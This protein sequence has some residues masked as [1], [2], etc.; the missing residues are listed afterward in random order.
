M[1]WRS[2]DPLVGVL[3]VVLIKNAPTAS[4]RMAQLARRAI[5]ERPIVSMLS[6]LILTGLGQRA[7]KR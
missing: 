3:Y 5:H 7:R 2:A 1:D 6:V 4:A